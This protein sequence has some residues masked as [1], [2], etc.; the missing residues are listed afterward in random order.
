MVMTESQWY[1][2]QE[3]FRT[4]MSYQEYLKREREK[5]KNNN[6]GMPCS[7]FGGF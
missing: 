3:H 1:K 5:K 2:S 4:E 6:S 7:G